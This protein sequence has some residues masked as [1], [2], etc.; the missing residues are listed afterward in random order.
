[1]ERI[2][3]C[4]DCGAVEG[5]YHQF[6]CDMESCPFCLNQL[7]SCNCSYELLGIDISEGTWAYKHGLTGEQE[8]EFIKM[9]EEKGRIPWVQIPVLCALCGEIF[10]Q[11]FS[12]PDEE[13]QK[14]VI[15]SLQHYLLCIICYEDQKKLF[16]NGWRNALP[17]PKGKMWGV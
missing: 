7:I 10:P 17:H 9:C 14:Y 15:P 12:V 6:G 16:P 2:G 13:W 8:E 1:M 5:Q 4:H 3:I 11:M